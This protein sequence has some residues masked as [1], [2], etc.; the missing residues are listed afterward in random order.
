LTRAGIQRLTASVAIT[1]SVRHTRHERKQ[2]QGLRL[3]PAVV[4]AAGAKAAKPCAPNAR[5]RKARALL[6]PF[7]Q[8]LNWHQFAFGHAMHIAKL[9]HDG[10]HTL[11]PEFGYFAL[12]VNHLFG[13]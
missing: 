4:L 8:V 3:N 13:L 11:R 9:R 7:L 2:P 10:M 6:Y 12:N 5:S 1:H